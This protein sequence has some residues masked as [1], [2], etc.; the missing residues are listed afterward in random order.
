MFRTILWYFFFFSSVFLSIPFMLKAKSLGKKGL[1]KEQDALVHKVTSFWGRKLIQIAGVKINVIG[2]ENLPKD[3]TVLFIGNHQGNFDIPIYLSC[4]NAPKGFVSKVE[5]EKI[6]GVRTWM[7]YMHCV[8]MDRGDL[9]KSGRAIIQSIKN[10]KSGHNM[11]I[12]PE[13]T[14]SK[15]DKMGE[16]KAGSFK[17]ATKSKCPIVPIT[18]DGSYK[19]ME[20]SV[21]KPW[22][23]PAEVNFYI[24]PAIEVS[25]LSEEEIEEL[26]NKVYN[27]IESKLPYKKNN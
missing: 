13:G 21:K 14:R 23:T 8:F 7:T 19:I 5:V 18:M 3:K 16:F 17:L 11:V 1:V 15:G 2:E 20:S 9:K 24:H 27:I 25:S 26:P 10:L 6:P 4:L 22:F 12:F